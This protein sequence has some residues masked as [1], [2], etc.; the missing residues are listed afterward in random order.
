MSSVDQPNPYAPPLT[1]SGVYTL[2][3][4]SD[5]E[6]DQSS[7][8][9]AAVPVLACNL[10][11]AVES[12]LRPTATDASAALSIQRSGRGRPVWWQV[13]CLLLL[14]LV[15]EWAAFHRRWLT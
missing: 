11:D 1:E 3:T 13:V 8:A 15:I 9:A 4:P 14:L 2:T 7:A 10:F 6:V 12:D 5:S